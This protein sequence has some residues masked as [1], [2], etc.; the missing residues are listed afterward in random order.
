M[1]FLLKLIL[2][3]FI[4]KLSKCLRGPAINPEKIDNPS[5][6]VFNRIQ[7]YIIKISEQYLKSSDLMAKRKISGILPDSFPE[8][9]KKRAEATRDDK[10]IWNPLLNKPTDLY[11]MCL[12]PFAKVNYAKWCNN[13]FLG[14]KKKLDSINI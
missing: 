9:M 3:L 7:N 10:K 6:G 11:R 14:S 8:D 2:I 5:D 1:K 4:V 13:T 12:Y